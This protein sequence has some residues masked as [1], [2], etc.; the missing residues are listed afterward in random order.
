MNSILLKNRPDD[1]DAKEFARV[2]DATGYALSALYKTINELIA[3]NEGVKASDFDC[4][5]HYAKLAYQAGM[6][7]A[8]KKIVDMLPDSAKY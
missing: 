7:E 4:P 8:F 6:N 1:A 5:N 2:W 3:Q